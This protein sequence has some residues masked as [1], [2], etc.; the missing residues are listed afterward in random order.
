MASVPSREDETVKDNNSASQRLRVIDSKIKVLSIEQEPR[1]EFRFVQSVLL[2]DRRIDPKFLLFQSDPKLAM[3]TGSPYL[4]KFPPKA[5]LLGYDLVIIGDVD[6]K[7]FTPEQM[8]TLS[9]FVSKFGG[10][11]I[12]IAGQQY[13]PVSYENTPLAKLLPVE[14][15]AP[16]A[17]QRGVTNHPTTLALT[18]LGRTNPMLKLSP[19]EQQNAEIWRNFPPIQWRERRC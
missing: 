6:V 12:F 7:S 18:G 16:S 15:E 19:E 8:D 9:E 13:D 10:A 14:V 1:W 3:G 11:I 2:R 17:F 4:E 5:D